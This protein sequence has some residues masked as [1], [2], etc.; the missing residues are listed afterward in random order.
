MQTLVNQVLTVQGDQMGSLL[1]V[2]QVCP[3][4][5]GHHHDE[6]AII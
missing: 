4:A 5:A 1:L 2:G 3:D 6:S